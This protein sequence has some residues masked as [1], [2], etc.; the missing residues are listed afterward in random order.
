[1]PPGQKQD[2]LDRAKQLKEIFNSKYPDYIYRRRPMN[3]R[4]NKSKPR[5]DM[6]GLV[7]QG[8]TPEAVEYYGSAHPEGD[9]RQYEGV[10]NIAHSS[11][12]QHDYIGPAAQAKSNPYPY[13]TPDS[14]HRHE[15]SHDPRMHFISQQGERLI[16]S[17]HAKSSGYDS[18]AQSR[19]AQIYPADAGETQGRWEPETALYRPLSSPKLKSYRLLPFS[20]SLEI[21]LEKMVTG[22]KEH[23]KFVAGAALHAPT[24]R[25]WAEMVFQESLLAISSCEKKHDQVKSAVRGIPTAGKWFLERP[26]YRTWKAG[27]SSSFPLLLTGIPGSGKTVISSVVIDDLRGSERPVNAVIFLYC[28][29]PDHT[30]YDTRSFLG[31]L[32][33]QLLLQLPQSK[34]SAVDRL[35]RLYNAFQPFDFEALIINISRDYEKVFV[36]ID[37]LDECKDPVD[38]L[39]SLPD[40]WHVFITSLR[41]YPVRNAYANFNRVVINSM[42]TIADIRRFVRLE[43]KKIKVQN[44]KLARCIV[45]KLTL[46][47]HGSF[48]WPICHMRQL[49]RLWTEYQ[50]HESLKWLP[51]GIDD[52]FP[53]AL[54]LESANQVWG[55]TRHAIRLVRLAVRPMTI[56]ELAE[57][58]GTAE[59]NGQQTSG[60]YAARM[61]MDM[62]ID[63]CSDLIRIPADKQRQPD[64]VVPA[65]SLK[66][67]LFGGAAH[68][69]VA[70]LCLTYLK[71]KLADYSPAVLART[72]DH[73]FM[74]YAVTGCLDHIRASGTDSLATE[75]RAFFAPGSKTFEG[76]CRL[77]KKQLGK[78]ATSGV[79][80]HIERLD[81]AHLAV[82]FDLPMILRKFSAAELAA[83][84]YRG[85][86]TLHVAVGIP[87]SLAAIDCL[88][89]KV[90]INS[91]SRYGDTAL[92]IA[93]SHSKN[94]EMVILRFW[95]ADVNVHAKDRAGRTALHLSILNP[96]RASRVPECQ[97][98]TAGDYEKIIRLLLDN[99]ADIESQDEA[100]N[101]PLHIASENVNASVS[102]LL[103]ERGASVISRNKHGSMAIHLA[104]GNVV[105]D[106]SMIRFRLQEIRDQE[107]TVHA[108]LDRGADVNA[109]IQ[110]SQ[111]PLHLAARSR[112]E[113]CIFNALLQKG[114]AVTANDDDGVTAL[115]LAVK[116][117]PISN[118]NE[119]EG[120][121]RISWIAC[122]QIIEFL[123]ENGCDPST[124]HGIVEK[125]CQFLESHYPD[126]VTTRDDELKPDH[127][128]V[129]WFKDVV[130]LLCSKGATV[131]SKTN[132]GYDI[133]RFAMESWASW[134]LEN[135]QILAARRRSD[136]MSLI[137]TYLAWSDIAKII[138]R[139]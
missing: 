79:G 114:A 139:S 63:G 42:D 82:W 97:G 4:L 39:E 62:L 30:K 68:N 72:S 43:V 84:D 133:L 92:H 90:D 91:L 137:G 19:Q 54:R 99:D 74:R 34:Y 22:N 6:T 31:N 60:L 16:N 103:L 111:T 76:W 3:Y 56:P 1:M 41:E 86:N 46:D 109:T 80:K 85:L 27:M 15:S 25:Q 100:G 28:E 108:L 64:F 107:L 65:P 49:R 135:H 29:S 126:I 117:A 69:D 94:P 14:P 105:P 93:V 67:P 120:H 55:R 83:K 129:T 123:I 10:A 122:R 21:E 59:S 102:K 17:F 2:Y 75:F 51:Q 58:L 38:L 118:V 134:I 138:P 13:V 53:R 106:S 121:W 50:I 124:L 77:Y 66:V 7:D 32:F 110:N 11:R 48:F 136:D 23:F 12:I 98:S 8:I 71:S 116:M 89:D 44:P 57:A 112:C 5:H 128:S 119:P 95:R 81:C 40:N 127:P 130:I 36:V 125:V 35:V 132:R 73:P 113:L 88:L 104:V 18:S 45:D 26:E 131:S 87:S 96:E 61:D 47:A 37:S 115:H 78:F 70:K 9:D 33:G 101:T 52:Q 20:K 24:E